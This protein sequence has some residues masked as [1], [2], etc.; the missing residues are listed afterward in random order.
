M[1]W[2]IKLRQRI[3]QYLGRPIPSHEQIDRT[4]GDI[5][6]KA[7][8]AEVTIERTQ[9]YLPGDDHPTHFAQSQDDEADDLPES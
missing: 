6:D 1:S 3:G 5:L 4:I 2:D 8:R 9:I 7:E